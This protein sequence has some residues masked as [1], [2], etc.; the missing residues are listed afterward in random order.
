MDISSSSSSGL[1]DAMAGVVVLLGSGVEAPLT[2]D[3]LAA[4]YQ[5]TPSGSKG[6]VL[7]PTPL[8]STTPGVT[9]HPSMPLIPK[10]GVKQGTS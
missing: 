3:R 5:L 10:R 1:E 7:V 8:T 6:M 4:I 9:S 2:R